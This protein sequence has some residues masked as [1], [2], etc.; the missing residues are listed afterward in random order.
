[1]NQK[2]ILNLSIRLAGFK[3]VPADT[4]IHVL[5]K[6]VQRPWVSIDVGAWEL[7]MAREIGCDSVI[8]HHPLGT[9]SANFYKVLYRHLDFMYEEGVPEKE[10]KAAVDQLVQKVKL[11][12]HPSIYRQVVEEAERIEMPLMNVHLPCDE[13]GRKLMDA[14][15]AKAGPRLEDIVDALVTMPEFKASEIK[16][17]V[18]LGEPRARRGR[19]KLVV[20]AGTN[21]GY[22]VARAYYKHG[23]DTLIYMHIDNEELKKLKED[24]MAKNLV[25]LGHES[26]DSVG[27]NPLL[28]E[29]RK[30]G[31]RPL[32]AGIL[33]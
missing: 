12:A 8:A 28:C 4:G 11:K 29:L 14:V 9:T 19:T 7:M 2:D 22:P 5:G 18:V 27:I 10:A 6:K 26:G 1:L 17:E 21:G 33:G 20:A 13:I 32:T 25:L 23:I 16:P 30:R 3:Q 24:G 31:I 15:I